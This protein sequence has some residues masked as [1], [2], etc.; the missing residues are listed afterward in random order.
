MQRGLASGNRHR[1]VHFRSVHTWNRPTVSAQTS[2]GEKL[3][4]VVNVIIDDA[5]PVD[6][7]VHSVD[8]TGVELVQ[9]K[10][11]AKKG[12]PTKYSAPAHYT[13]QQLSNAVVQVQL[14]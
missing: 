1:L 9:I 5:D 6:A 11:G 3:G 12:M 14:K 2:L 4:R 7:K 10:P 13:Y 8:E